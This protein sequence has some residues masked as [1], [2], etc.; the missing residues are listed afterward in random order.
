MGLADLLDDNEDDAWV[1]SLRE[2]DLP[3]TGF[4]GSVIEAIIREASKKNPGEVVVKP[5]PPEP[6]QESQPTPKKSKSKRVAYSVACTLHVSGSDYQVQPL[7]PLPDYEKAYR[8]NKLNAQ[9]PTGYNVVQT[10]SGV[11]ICE[12]HDF[13]YRQDGADSKGCKHIRALI[14]M[15]F[16]SSP[17]VSRR[18]GPGIFDG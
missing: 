5:G 10:G 2:R 9:K 18:Q 8:L 7:P 13:K 12:C 3:S 14:D 11:I 16:F 1:Q 17:S 15:G 6:E 4:E